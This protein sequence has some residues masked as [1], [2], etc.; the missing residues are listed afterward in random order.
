MTQKRIDVD[1]LGTTA[2]NVSELSSTSE[3]TLSCSFS[4]NR[5]FVPKPNQ[6]QIRLLDRK[7]SAVGS[8]LRLSK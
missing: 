3:I 1:A 4:R 5:A 2:S 8:G 6:M 7:A